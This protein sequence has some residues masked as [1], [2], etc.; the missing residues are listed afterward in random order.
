MRILILSWYFPPSSTMGAMRVGKFAEFLIARGHD[1]RVITPR[2]PPHPQ[3]LDMDL[4]PGTAR[5]TPWIDVT[6]FHKAIAGVIKRRAGRGKSKPGGDEA[7]P[8]SRP[9]APAPGAGGWFGRC[10]GRLSDFYV[11][12]VNFPDG[13]I[14]WLPYAVAEG[15]RC[16][17]QWPADIIF[18]SGPPFTTLLAG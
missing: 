2:D 3:T 5:L 14:G 13:R 1:V 15:R 7:S 18:A 9:P 12:I 8:D 17:R 16:L 6:K 11:R 4:P 10:A